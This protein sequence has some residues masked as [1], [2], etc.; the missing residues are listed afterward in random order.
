MPLF[1]LLILFLALYFLD[2]S[3]FKLCTT[4]TESTPTFSLPV[5]PGEEETE[6]EELDEL[7]VELEIEYQTD[8]E[9]KVRFVCPC[10]AFPCPSHLPLPSVGNLMGYR[11][12]Y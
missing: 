4:G 5:S 6:A 2:T 9:G 8:E 12:F 10:F 11:L 1:V 3:K 7:E